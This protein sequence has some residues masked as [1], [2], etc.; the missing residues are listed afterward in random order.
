MAW[1]FLDRRMLLDGRAE[2]FLQRL[3]Y[4]GGYCTREQVLWLGLAESPT[5]VRAH[6]N[7]LLE[8]RFLHREATYPIVYHATKLATRLLGT[9]CRARRPHTI[10]T[11]RTRLLGVNYYL[12]ACQHQGEFLFN[13]DRKV[14]AFRERGCRLDELPQRGGQPYLRDEFVLRR[15]DGSLCVAIID[16]A[17]KD[18]RKQVWNLAKRFLPCL[19]RLGPALELVVAA[20]TKP[21][22]HL[23]CQ[24]VCHPDL[25][26]LAN[27]RFEV[28]VTPYL[29]RSG[30]P[31]VWPT[32]QPK[33]GDGPSEIEASHNA[34]VSHKSY[35]QG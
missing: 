17:H 34:R 22:Y 24:L 35:F 19:K 29:V 6:L 30:T 23:Y 11:V 1:R 25:Q 21:R 7:S 13:H 8:S 26:K 2:K 12:E 10:Q 32:A 28:S 9:D 14:A 27:G 33:S 15:S 3:V 5:R 20:G 31:L 4:L 16:H 18:A